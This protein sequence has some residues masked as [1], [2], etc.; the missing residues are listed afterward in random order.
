M[1]AKSISVYKKVT[2]WLLF[3]I[4]FIFIRHDKLDISAAS[5]GAR[6][7]F[8]T[9][10]DEP[11]ESVLRGPWSGAIT[12]SSVCVKAQ[13]AKAG[14]KSR[15]IVS[16]TDDF[17]N[18]IYSE[19]DTALEVNDLVVSFQINRLEPDTLYHYAIEVDGKRDDGKKGQFKTFSD[20]PMS[21]SF[22]YGACQKTG[23]DHRT[24][25]TILKKNPLF[26][27]NI[28]DFHYQ[29]IGVNDRKLYRETY[30]ANLDSPSQADLYRCVPFIYIWDN[31]DYSAPNHCDSSSP[32]KEAACLTYQEYVPH[33]PLPAGKGNVPIYQTFTVGR[34]KFILMDLYSE[35]SPKNVPKNKKS[36][37]GLNQKLWLKQELL[38]SKGKYPLLFLISTSVWSNAPSSWG[39]FL[40]EKREIADFI[41]ENQITGVCILSADIHAL[42]ADDGTHSDFAT[43]KGAPIPVCYAAPL[44]QYGKIAGGPY[45]QGSYV[46]VANEGCFGWVTVR[47]RE[48]QIDV[49]YSGRNDQDQEKVS[50]K[51]SVPVH[52]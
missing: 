36:I 29:D 16:K 33:Y 4:V 34:V 17:L 49:E 47:D 7:T 13:I 26:F 30:H 11:A 25:K 48:E 9:L 22:A 5:N 42:A 44:A 38:Q 43:N 19:I 35:R 1:S 39:G 21:F 32:S 14:A 15:L 40:E 24:Y 52:K 2:V 31:H 28:G 27:M 18:P 6:G 12:S 23:A 10:A 46:P 3:T 41:K 51:F 45:S 8:G 37:L 50:L 20:N